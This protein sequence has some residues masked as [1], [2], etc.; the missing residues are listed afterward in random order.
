MVQ[1]LFLFVVQFVMEYVNKPKKGDSMNHFERQK[2]SIHKF[3]K[4]AGKNEQHHLK[5]RSRGGQDIQS[6]LVKL[7]IYRHD[8]FHLL[9]GNRTLKEVIEILTRLQH[10]K[11]AQRFKQLLT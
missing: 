4:R 11:E 10:I 7:D 6:N 3:K 8:A 1:L 5:P 9:F 2:R